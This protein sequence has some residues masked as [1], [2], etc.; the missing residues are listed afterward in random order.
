[1]G[2]ILN[3]SVAKR[4]SLINFI[5]AGEE[6]HVIC[7]ATVY[8]EANVEGDLSSSTTEW[9]QLSGTPNDMVIEVVDKTRSYYVVG[10]NI[11][12]D[13]VF[14]FYINRGTAAE[15]YMDVNIRTTPSSTLNTF[16]IGEPS[17][18]V[19]QPP[20]I[21]TLPPIL[22]AS[23]TVLENMPDN[24]GFV[25]APVEVGL[26]WSLPQFFQLGT[27]EETVRYE[28]GFL[29]TIVEA[30]DGSSWVVRKS[31]GRYET[32]VHDLGLDTR[33]RIG[34]LYFIDGKVITV[35]NDWIDISFSD[36]LITISNSVLS[37][38]DIGSGYVTTDIVRTVFKLENKIYSE[39]VDQSLFGQPSVAL[40]MTRYVFILAPQEHSDTVGMY[41]F[42]T[43]AT[44]FNITRVSGASIGG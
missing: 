35:Y 30:W 13:K 2:Q 28:K 10:Q 23:F 39:T 15:Q 26:Q 5:D 31:V 33:I 8:L 18:S 29:G 44:T 12:T 6:Q 17:V 32:R 16:N 37:Q 27:N 4:L 43:G 25:L 20:L 40:D 9:V 3:I 38:T 11:G 22:A 34:A 36:T 19:N 24:T 7:A 21:E 42:G 1:M 41:L 14:R